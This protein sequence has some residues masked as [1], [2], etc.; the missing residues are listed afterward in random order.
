MTS[1]YNI[2]KYGGQHWVNIGDFQK[3]VRNGSTRIYIRYYIEESDSLLLAR[4]VNVL[5]TNWRPFVIAWLCT[6]LFA[7]IDTCCDRKTSKT[8]RIQKYPRLDRF[9]IVCCDWKS[10]L[11]RFHTVRYRLCG[12]HFEVEVLTSGKYINGCRKISIIIA[13]VHSF[14]LTVNNK[15]I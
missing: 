10:N 13:N 11:I 9:I 3:W 14:D 5:V 2:N 1:R 12:G 15:T 6:S 4:W 7:V 8:C